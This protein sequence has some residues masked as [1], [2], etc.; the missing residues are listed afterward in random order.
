[1][2]QKLNVLIVED[3][4]LIRVFLKRLVLSQ[5]HNIVAI[6]D[7]GA[8]ALACIHSENIDLIFMDIN[9]N[10]PLDGIS[11]IQ[12]MQIANPPIVYFVSAYS[13][14]ETIDEALNTVALNY[15]TK[16]I[17]ESDILIA[18]KVAQKAQKTPSSKNKFILSY[19]LYYDLQVGALYQD[20]KQIKLT[21]LEKLLVDLF[22]LNANNNVSV[23]SIV[24]TVWK[25]KEVSDST[26]R[27]TI[28]LLRKKVPSLSLENNVG[29]GYTLLVTS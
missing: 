12:K 3:E 8:S 27:S 25:D 18:L 29:R 6:H 19:A 28:S 4:P 7:D 22:V 20:E 9:I 14:M 24:A 5:G 11:V 2:Q 21:K 13:D 10:G 1:M 16:P 17:K 26:V 15:I 23:E